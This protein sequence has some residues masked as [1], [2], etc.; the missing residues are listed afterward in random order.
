MS[1]NRRLKHPNGCRREKSIALRC[2]EVVEPRYLLAQ[3][4]GTLSSDILDGTD[5]DDTITGLAGNDVI[6]S[7]GGADVIDA[8]SGDDRIVVD[9]D[10]G[11]VE[12]GT[13]IDTLELRTES[14]IDLQNANVANIEV[15]DLGAPGIDGQLVLTAASV[16]AVT[17]SGNTLFVTRDS[18]NDTVIIG[19]GWT[20]ESPE[21]VDSQ[22]FEVLTQGASTLKIEV[23][24]AKLY[25]TDLI[26]NEI[27]DGATIAN[28]T[29][30]R[31]HLDLP[32]VVPK[33]FTQIT[34]GL[35]ENGILDTA[36]GV[37]V[38]QR[39]G[40]GWQADFTALRRESDWIGLPEY[41]GEIPGGSIDGVKPRSNPLRSGEIHVLQ[42]NGWHAQK[43]S[44]GVIDEQLT[45]VFEP[46][47][48][49]T[50]SNLSQIAFEVDFESTFASVPHAFEFVFERQ[51][52]TGISS[53]IRQ[54][55]RVRADGATEGHVTVVLGVREIEELNNAFLADGLQYGFYGPWT[56]KANG[57]LFGDEV[58]VSSFRVTL[59]F[60]STLNIAGWR[61]LSAAENYPGS[62]TPKN[63]ENGNQ[64]YLADRDG[65]RLPLGG[66]E[67]NAVVLIHGWNP[68]DLPFSDHYAG[69]GSS[70]SAGFWDE[71]EDRL[72]YAVSLSNDW[73]LGLYDWVN[74]AAT[75]NENVF[76][77]PVSALSSRDAAV[78][79]GYFLGQAIEQLF[80]NN[81][82]L[83][84]V[85][86]IAHSAGN[87]VATEASSHLLAAGFSG[88]IQ[89][90]S[91]DAFVPSRSFLLPNSAEIDSVRIFE[92]V[93]D[94]I[95]GT[96]YILDNY[97]VSD[98]LDSDN[99]TRWTSEEFDGWTITR[100]LD[101]LFDPAPLY[102]SKLHGAH[103]GP[104]GWYADTIPQMLNDDPELLKGDDNRYLGFGSSFLYTDL[105]AID[106]EPPEVIRHSPSDVV[107]A[108]VNSVTV[109]FDEPI[110][111]STFTIAD[112]V[113]FTGPSSSIAVTSVTPL[114]GTNN[115]QFRMAFG[116]TDEPG[117]YALTFGPN[118]SDASNNVMN[119]AYTATFTIGNPEIPLADIVWINPNGGSWHDKENWNL[120]RVPADGDVVLIGDFGSS[121]IVIT[122]T[123]GSVELEHLTVA[124]TLN[125]AGGVLDVNGVVQVAGTLRLS[126]ATLRDASVLGNAVTIVGD[127]I[128]H[129]VRLES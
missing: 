100:Q 96:D 24:D 62:V 71:L 57:L 106:V 97:Y 13:G 44:D 2:C 38:L 68:D 101:A 45:V 59:T 127:S 29:E 33:D 116:G 124:E 25:W 108:S 99:V 47:D 78:S 111:P 9:A 21:V 15:I 18:R 122:Y 26:G 61:S 22:F 12:G 48:I 112:I 72:S 88:R 64:G 34:A 98:F 4:T 66:N 27:A 35:Y 6:S 7:G 73:I 86:F 36:V 20:S 89:I 54:S 30:V 81:S 37:L 95:A 10:F 115:Q 65:N 40:T 118:I 90:T 83:E 85:Q 79:H 17:D 87:W 128:L 121:D 32:T 84:T 56:L 11:S 91:L 52:P 105:A 93:R 31:M 14:T 102:N 76:E 5:E 75:G 94:K 58:D 3:I 63:A 1:H 19:I 119:S 23:P 16:A 49:P 125:I 51:G 53:D 104:I 67:R 123:S 46:G 120:D 114:P 113:S 39:S 43:S 50:G 8:G 74:D 92:A 42:G 129:G 110:V 69:D 28:R 55:V 77:I 41:F 107:Y 117:S 126:N 82:Q 60:Y 70:S 80:Q 109:T 103:N